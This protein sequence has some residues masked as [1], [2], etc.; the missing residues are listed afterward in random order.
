MLLIWVFVNILY[1]CGKKRSARPSV[2]ENQKAGS[3][4]KFSSGQA[5]TW[6]PKTV[7]SNRK[8]LV[9]LFPTLDLR[10]PV[11]LLVA[12][13]RAHHYSRLD[14]GFPFNFSLITS[15]IAIDCAVSVVWWNSPL[16]DLVGLFRSWAGFSDNIYDIILIMKM[17][18]LTMVIWWRH[19]DNEGCW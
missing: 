5:S 14:I 15:N 3:Y 12:K 17:I 8:R 6:V 18:I 13:S 1:I 11:K 9:F 4:A 10:V 16:V 19:V 7:I 2:V